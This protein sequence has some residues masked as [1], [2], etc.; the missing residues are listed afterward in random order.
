MANA[1]QKR[2]AKQQALRKERSLV[3]KEERWWQALQHCNRYE[4]AYLALH[5]SHTS[6]RYVK[7]WYLVHGKRFR[8]VKI[9][10]MATHLE[11]L[12]HVQDNPQPENSD[13]S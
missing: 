4:A 9:I 6:V 2:V 8:E 3:F 12:K 5:G 10:Q 11:V 7:G 1:Y 13:E